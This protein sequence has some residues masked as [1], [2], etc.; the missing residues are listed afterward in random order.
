MK[1]HT[2]LRTAVLIISLLVAAT[3]SPPASAQKGSFTETLDNP[4]LPDWER[5][6]GVTVLDGI[7]RI[8][9]DNYAFH[10]ANLET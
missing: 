3:L 8:Y 5:S 9:P 2:K 6:P 1:H 7:L 10:P 4:D